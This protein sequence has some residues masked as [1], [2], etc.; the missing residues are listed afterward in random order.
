MPWVA[1]ETFDTYSPGATLHG[2]AGGVNWSGSWA[3][4]PTTGWTVET[5][6]AGGQGGLAARKTGTGNEI[7]QRNLATAISVGTVHFKARISATPASDQFIGFTLS[8]GSDRMLIKFSNGGQI[9][10][11]DN[12]SGYV[13]IQAFSA[14]T[15]YDIDVDFD[16]A[17][18]NNLYR[19][20][21]DGGSYTTYKTVNGG[22]YTTIDRI[23]LKD[24]HTTSHTFWVDD[25]RAVGER[26]S[27]LGRFG[28]SQQITTGFAA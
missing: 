8:D 20:R 27:G 13:N 26:D 7:S 18:Q 19:A 4:T 23:F 1:A 3:N 16:D 14:D 12:A 21:V 5:A 15:W 2:A 9:Q 28:I 24:T 22:S 25:I 11:F 10:I 6:P 17:A